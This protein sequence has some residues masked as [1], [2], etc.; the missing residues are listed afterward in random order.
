MIELS[1]PYVGDPECTGVAERFM[2]TL[3]EHGLYLHRFA[4]LAEARRIIGEFIARYN[5]E[6]LIA[7]LGYRTP[8][9]AR[10]DA[11]AAAA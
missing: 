5:A 7:R 10:R 9:Q 2:R 11:V 8:T 6:W 3:K 4:S 1:P